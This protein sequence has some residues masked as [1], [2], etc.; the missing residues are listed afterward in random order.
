MAAVEVNVSSANE[1]VSIFTVGCIYIYSTE[2][3]I[4]NETLTSIPIKTH[5]QIYCI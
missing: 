3:F 2:P 4:S 5:T 1:R